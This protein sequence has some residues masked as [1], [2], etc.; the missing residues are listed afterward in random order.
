[1]IPVLFYL[2]D[3][4]KSSNSGYFVDMM[5][6]SI[7]PRVVLLVLTL[8]LMIFLVHHYYYHAKH[9][10][11]EGISKSEIEDQEQ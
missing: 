4:T 8:P 9:P 7:S 6:R 5:N 10:A 2:T 3:Q 11:T 1:M